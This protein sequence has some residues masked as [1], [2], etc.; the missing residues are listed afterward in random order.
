SR[1]YVAH[2]SN[3]DVD[4][5]DSASNRFLRSIHG[6]KGVAGVLASDERGFLFTA[7]R[8][9]NTISIFAAGTEKELARLSAGIRPNGLAFEP[10]RG[11]LLVANVGDPEIGNSSTVSMIDVGEKT[12]IGT[13]VLPGRPRW[14]VYNERTAAFYVNIAD[15]PLIV[16]IEAKTPWT[17]RERYKV[18]AKGPHGLDLDPRGRQLFCAC[19]GQK[20]VAVHLDS[21]EIRAVGELS[22]P[23][24]V[25]SFNQGLGHVYVAVRAISSSTTRGPLFRNGSKPF[26]ETA[27]VEDKETLHRLAEWLRARGTKLK[28]PI[29]FRDADTTEKVDLILFIGLEKWYPPMYD[30][31]AC[32]YGTCNEFLRASPA[33]HTGEY[34]DWEF[35]GPICQLRCIDLGIAVGSAAK[36][37]SMNNVDTRCQT[38]VAA[39][40]RHLGIIHS[41]LAVAL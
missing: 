20:L 30:C 8:A 36:L 39:A 24:D 40:A 1:L 29:F 17:I 6:L 27:I 26:I 2:T 18:P 5:I 37:A 34:Q 11:L 22:G 13:V 14:A 33:H 35:L 7:N 9:E 15:P 19:D 28:N 23:P 25:V 32:G 31:G 21:G 4:V 3:D 12:V 41:D 38:R 16:E 10:S